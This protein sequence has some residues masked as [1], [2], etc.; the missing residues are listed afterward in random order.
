[1]SSAIYKYVSSVDKVIKFISDELDI[2]I[3]ERHKELIMDKIYP[4]IKNKINWFFEIDDEEYEGMITKQEYEIVQ[5]LSPETDIYFN[6]WSKEGY[7]CKLKD[8]EFKHDIDTL[9]EMYDK[10]DI[11]YMEQ[12]NEQFDLMDFLYSNDIIDNN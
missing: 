10:G 12:Q 6:G 9:K 3:T 5:K 11:Y 7:Y 4:N 1:M 2:E 8:I